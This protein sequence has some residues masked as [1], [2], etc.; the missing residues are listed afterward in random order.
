[1]TTCL[2]GICINTCTSALKITHFPGWRGST[3][4]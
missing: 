3:S 2:E 4:S 1:M